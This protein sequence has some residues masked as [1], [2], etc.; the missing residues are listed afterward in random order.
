MRT[1]AMAIKHPDEREPRVFID[2]SMFSRETLEARLLIS[3]VKTWLPD[4]ASDGTM[5]DAVED[6][7]DLG[8][9]WAFTHL[10]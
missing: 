6:L 8:C 3:A 1:A 4:W 5:F 2:Q 7:D 10:E 9:T